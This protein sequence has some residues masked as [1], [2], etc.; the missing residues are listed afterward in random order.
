MKISCVHKYIGVDQNGVGHP[1]TVSYNITG[2]ETIKE[3]AEKIL[4]K[5][6][7]GDYGHDC[8]EI[9]VALDVQEGK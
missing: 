6:C 4:N 7:T 2:N 8:F 3:L 9:R 5:E 1:T